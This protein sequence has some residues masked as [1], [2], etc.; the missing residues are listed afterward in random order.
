MEEKDL[1]QAYQMVRE[2]PIKPVETFDHKSITKIEGPSKKK[3]W[4]PIGIG[5][6][7]TIFFL[8]LVFC[9]LRFYPKYALVKSLDLWAN[10]A[11]MMEKASLNSNQYNWDE[12]TTKGTATMKIGEFLLSNLEEDNEEFS[13]L[14][15]L[16]SLSFDIE[17][18]F[19]KKEHKF[20]IGMNG[21]LENESIFNV[22]YINDNQKQYLLLKEV[23][24][25]YL[26]LENNQKIA[27]GNTDTELF[28]DDVTHVWNVLKKSFKKNIKSSYIKKQPEKIIINGKTVR[29]TKISLVIDEKA[30]YE[31]SK[32]IIK[33]LKADKRAYDFIINL[34]PAFAEYEEVQ[35]RDSYYICYS[36]NV[37]KGIPKIVK[38]SLSNHEEKRFS[39]IKD[40]DYIFELEDSGKLQFR[41]IMR[42]ETDGFKMKIQLLE[43]NIEMLLVGKKED[44]STTYHLSTETN[45]ATLEV[46]STHTLKEKKKD[47]VKENIQLGFEIKAQGMA[48][49]IATINFDIETKKGAVFDEIKDSKLV[50]DLTEEEQEKIKL[51][52]ENIGKLFAK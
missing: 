52:F 49:E 24:E 18:R 50:T 17:N 51:Y 37:K 8:L 14:Q 12:M 47:S 25:N 21:K 40:D 20:F 48:L 38:A 46:I 41:I 10:S 1:E 31:L 26:Q 23:F 44:N 4:L 7:I 39:V 2:E 5:V 36:V 6:V 19:N 22:G 15:K 3:K 32:N 30:D 29:T 11:D 43:N 42:D 33:D 35:S 27:V 13:I 9:F 28:Y 45:G 16:N 34:Y